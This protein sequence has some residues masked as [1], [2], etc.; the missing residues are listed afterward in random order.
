M[1][2]RVQ[3]HARPA[4]RDRQADGR[5]DQRD[6]VGG[7][8]ELQMACDLAVMVDDAF[9]RHVGPEHGSVPA[10]GA[11]QWLPI[12]VG[13]RRAREIL[14]LC[15]RDP[16]EAGR[17]VGPDQPGRAARTSSTRRSTPTSSASPRSSAD[18]ALHEAAAE[19]VA[20]PL[21]A[22]HRRPRARLARALDAERRDEGRDRRLPEPPPLRRQ[23]LTGRPPARDDRR[24]RNLKGEE[25][26]GGNLHRVVTASGAG[27]PRGVPGQALGR[28]LSMRRKERPSGAGSG[29]RPRADGLRSGVERS[30][31]ERVG[32]AGRGRLTGSGAGGREPGARS[33]PARGRP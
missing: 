23:R 29:V 15:E 27:H 19:L 32:E 31:R 17:G 10:G 33:L 6:R 7:G 11:T 20:R 18:D 2:R 26:S 25:V 4:A 3:G 14:L 8:N 21:L 9:I 13:D 1:V 30:T 22:R 12:F 16:R 24:A 5:P 28:K